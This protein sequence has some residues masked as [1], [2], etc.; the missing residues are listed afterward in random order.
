MGVGER[1]GVQAEQRDVRERDGGCDE[2]GGGGD[3]VGD[4]IVRRE[5]GVERGGAELGRERREERERERR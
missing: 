4:G 2:R 3:G 1:G 5:H